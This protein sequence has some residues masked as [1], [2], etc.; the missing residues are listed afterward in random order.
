MDT[1]GS[2]ISKMLNQAGY[3]QKDLADMA[4]VTEA[5]ISRYI[6]NERAPKAIIAANIATALGTTTDYLIEGVNPE[7]SIEDL[8]R[9]VGRS[10]AIMTKEQKLKMIKLLS[11][12]GK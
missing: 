5:A 1:I 9:L 6:K 2:R 3:T 11:E 12:D 8:F 10:T 7:E 4:G